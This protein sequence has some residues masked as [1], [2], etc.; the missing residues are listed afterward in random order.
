MKN[1]YILIHNNWGHIY[2]Y[3]FSVNQKA[4]EAEKK[5]AERIHG[6]YWYLIKRPANYKEQ[7]RLSKNNEGIVLWYSEEE[8][9]LGKKDKKLIDKFL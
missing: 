4:I 8:K 2:K 1:I 3:G 7:N 5:Q 9:E 6:G